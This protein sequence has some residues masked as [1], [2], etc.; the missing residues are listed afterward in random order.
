MKV[1]IYRSGKTFGPYSI[2]QLNQYLQEGKVLRSDLA[3]HDGKEWI[4]L[5]DV[6]GIFNPAT[7]PVS[8]EK[9]LLPKKPQ[10]AEIEKNATPKSKDKKMPWKIL[11]LAGVPALMITALGLGFYFFSGPSQDESLAK[12]EFGHVTD[13]KLGNLDPRPPAHSWRLP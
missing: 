10:I 6:P 4:K 1:F 8:L 9:P 5:S 2:N 7:K 12:T 3:C 13:S 11:L